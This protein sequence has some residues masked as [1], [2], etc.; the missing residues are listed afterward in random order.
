MECKR[1]FPRTTVNLPVKYD[2]VSW[3][4]SPHVLKQNALMAKSNDLSARGIRFTHE[5]N[6]TKKTV[7]KLQDG[8]VRL[9]LE[10]TL[11][12][13]EKSI[14][15][16][17]RVIYCG[18]DEDNGED[19]KNQCIGVYFLDISPNDLSRIDRFVQSSLDLT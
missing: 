3:D 13:E 8:S 2:V 7:K 18:E 17:G 10:F 5:L 9:N 16:L 11:P 14:N 1:K 6:L 15:I 19:I 12:N 4:D